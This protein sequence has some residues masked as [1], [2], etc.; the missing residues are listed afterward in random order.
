M[1]SL[2]GFAQDLRY[3]IRQLR[4]SP[5][6]TL[7]AVLSLALGI[8]ANTAIFQIVDAVRLRAL[9]VQNPQELVSVDFEP[10]SARSGWFS[11]R[12]ARFTYAHWEQIR[13][14][15]Q[16]FSGVMAWSAAR[17][18]LSDG[19]ETRYAE[20][21]FVSGDFF[22]V[23]GVKPALGRVFT[24]QDD[25]AACSSPGAVLSDSFWRR[26]FGGDPGALGRTVS[27]D[28]HKFP[29]IGVTPRAFFGVEVGSQYEIALPL[30]ADRLLAEDK[31]GRIPQ[32]IAWWLSIMGRLK[33]GWTPH[34]ATTSAGAFAGDHAVDDPFGIPA[35]Y[36]EAVPG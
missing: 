17:Y 14:Q 8:G 4:N 33:P 15:Q 18:N 21:L 25:T 5:G 32:R 28:G 36:R 19:G 31:K 26:E 10:K 13:K 23:L 9:P 27:L 35:G 16:A 22:S 24:A 30:C 3:G 7:V 2:H 34:K 11:T 29:V 12:S 20:G 1:T 6:F